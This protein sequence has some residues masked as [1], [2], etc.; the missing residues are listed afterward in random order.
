MIKFLL[1]GACIWVIMAGTS[2]CVST[3]PLQYMQGSFDTAK[4]STYKIPQAVI[5]KGDLLSIIVYSDNPAATAIYNQSV[6]GM[7]GATTSGGGGATGN[8]VSSSPGY[9]VDDSGNI[10]FQGIGTLH[11]DGLNKTQLTDSLNARLKI[12]LV[13]PYYNIRFLTYKI[14]LIGDVAKPGVYTIPSERVNILEALGLA[15]DL[16]I[17]ARRDN[18][19]VIREQNGKREWGRIDLTKPDIFASPFYQLNQNDMVYVDLSKSKAANSDQ[20]TV[21][22]I[23]LATSVISTAALIITILRR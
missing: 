3:R 19:L 13:N 2:S 1:F 17:T 15:G 8:A 4:L 10:Q 16:N 11:V 18:I 6:G 22:N 7:P 9:L 23:S 20:T 12:Y 14:T 5:Q 21:R